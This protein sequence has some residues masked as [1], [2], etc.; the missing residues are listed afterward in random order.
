MAKRGFRIHNQVLALILPRYEGWRSRFACLSL[1]FIV[2]N[3]LKSR[4]YETGTPARPY[5]YGRSG[6]GQST[7]GL[8]RAG[9]RELEAR[10]SA[11]I[12]DVLRRDSQAQSGVRACY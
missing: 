5:A 10:K 3:R 11:E 6:K 2:G 12:V 8:G 1:V 9:G 7:D 4:L